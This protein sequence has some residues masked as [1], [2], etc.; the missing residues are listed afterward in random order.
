MTCTTAAEVDREETIDYG[1]MPGV[2]AGISGDGLLDWA[3][4]NY[5]DR[6]L[7]GWIPLRI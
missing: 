4:G 3:N 7:S 5:P 6:H 1:A 2:D